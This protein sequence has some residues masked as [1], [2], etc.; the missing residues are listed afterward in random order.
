[1]WIK[2]LYNLGVDWPMTY[3]KLDPFYQQAEEIWGV[4]GAE[5]TGSPRS[6]PFPMEPVT[7]PYAM[8]R[9]RERLAPE[10]PGSG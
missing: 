3:A 10:V 5:N 8:R 7:E 6:Q 9:I 4:S 2:T 1:M